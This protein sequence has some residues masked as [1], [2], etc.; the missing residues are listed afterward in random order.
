MD[1]TIGTRVRARRIAVGMSQQRLAGALEI[2]FRKVEKYEKGINRVTAARLVGIA[3]V[4]GTTVDTLLDLDRPSVD[5]AIF[6]DADL[7]QLLVAYRKIPARKWKRVQQLCSDLAEF[8]SDRSGDDT[9]AK[10]KGRGLQEAQAAK[11]G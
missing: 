6:E 4:L 5:A 7:H 8:A 9:D 1:Q 11:K 10:P 2:T 3:H